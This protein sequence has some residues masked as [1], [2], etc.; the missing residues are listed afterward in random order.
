MDSCV[1]GKV[2]TLDENETN[3]FRITQFDRTNNKS[4]GTAINVWVQKKRKTNGSLPTGTNGSL[5]TGINGSLPTGINGSLPTGTNGS[6][7]TGTNGRLPTGINGSLPTGTNGSLPTGINGSLPTGINGSLPTGTNGSLPTGINGSLPTGING[8]LPTGTN[9]SL[10]TGTNGRLPTGTNG[11][12]PTGT[13]GRL[14]TGTNGSLRPTGLAFVTSWMENRAAVPWWWQLGEESARYHRCHFTETSED[15]RNALSQSQSFFIANTRTFPNSSAS[16]CVR[17]TV[18]AMIGWRFK[19]ICEA[20]RVKQ[21]RN[22]TK[23]RQA[24]AL[25][26]RNTEHLASRAC[27]I[28]AYRRGELEP[29]WRRPVR[30]EL[31]PNRN[32]RQQNETIDKGNCRWRLGLQCIGRRMF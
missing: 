8:S 20:C 19:K 4:I 21:T 14:P 28:Y 16:S 22:K 10:P 5:P 3:L 31:G 23:R 25:V 26:Y 1:F 11:R 27:C 29:N 6:L 30:G 9:G 7:P 18:V 17:D 2:F 32:N 13:N 12:L 15:L 24:V